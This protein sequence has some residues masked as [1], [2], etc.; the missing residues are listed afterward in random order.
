VITVC[1]N[2][3]ETCPVFFGAAEKLHH[4]FEDPPAPFVGP[5]DK[6]MTIFRRVRDELRAY[7]RD[8]TTRV[9]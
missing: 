1:D 5:D 3:R 8:F 6:R 4:S 9:A 2:A 7:L